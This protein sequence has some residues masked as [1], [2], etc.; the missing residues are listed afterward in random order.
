[1]KQWNDF[2]KRIGNDEIVDELE[3]IVTIKATEHNSPAAAKMVARAAMAH[4]AEK[5]IDNLPAE[6]QKVA[7][8]FTENGVGTLAGL[9]ENIERT[10]TERRKPLCKHSEDAGI[11][12]TRITSA[13][14]V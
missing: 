14:I 3:Q 7:R 1:M 9:R 5:Y 11:R 6:L 12:C 10:K 13:S 4:A 2:T 8:D